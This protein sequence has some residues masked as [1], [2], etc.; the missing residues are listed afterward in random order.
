MAHCVFRYIKILTKKDH[1]AKDGRQLEMLTEAMVKVF[2]AQKEL[3]A[4]IPG[5]GHLHKLVPCFKRKHAEM[6]ASLLSVCNELAGNDQGVRCFASIDCVGPI[7]MGL[8]VTLPSALS[9]GME[10]VSK[11]FE[12]N[13]APLVA[14]AIKVEMPQKL[15]E[16]LK[17]QLDTIE[18]GSAAKAHCVQALKAMGRDLTHGEAVNE[19]LD[20]CAWWATYKDQ[21]HDLFITQSSVAG[22]L[23]GPTAKVAG[24]LMAAPTTAAMGDEPPMEE[25]DDDE[26]PAAGRGR[27]ADLLGDD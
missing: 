7:K 9:S 20:A 6:S 11:L 10:L 27:L 25:S 26:A 13:Q 14:Q 23:T 2:N 15:L 12:A 18:G 3:A 24:Y 1:N 22:Y 17:S 21:R 4:Q 16:I 8:S 19:I 5:L